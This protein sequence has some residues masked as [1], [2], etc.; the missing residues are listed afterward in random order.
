MR[1]E[2]RVRAVRG[3]DEVVV[4][5]L[6]IGGVA[7]GFEMQRNPELAGAV[8]QDFEQALAADPDEAVPARS[9][10]FAPDMGRRYR[11]SGRT[12]R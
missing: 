12:P 6:R 8:L 9:D 10:A 11:P 7:F 4:A 5:P 2:A 1:R 3:D